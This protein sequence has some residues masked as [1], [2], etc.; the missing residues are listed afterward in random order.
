MLKRF[1]EMSEPNPHEID[2]LS[3]TDLIRI[4]SE[5]GLLLSDLRT[6]KVF[7]HERSITSHNLI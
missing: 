3:F 1:L 5:K 2:T 6:W 4:G 7:R